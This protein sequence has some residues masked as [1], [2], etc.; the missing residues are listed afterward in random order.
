MSAPKKTEDKLSI[1]E[2]RERLPRT[3]YDKADWLEKEFGHSQRYIPKMFLIFK[4]FG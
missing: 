4:D 1:E 3:P 2:L